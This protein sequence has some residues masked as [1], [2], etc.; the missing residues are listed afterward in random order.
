[1]MKATIKD[2][3]DDFICKCYNIRSSCS[4]CEYK[5]KIKSDIS[6]RHYIFCASYAIMSTLNNLNITDSEEY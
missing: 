2:F 3:I 6:D 5:C 1:M 4:D